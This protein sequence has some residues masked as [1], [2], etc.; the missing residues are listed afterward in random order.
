[1][2]SSVFDWNESLNGNDSWRNISYFSLV[3]CGL[4]ISS[5]ICF[6]V[7]VNWVWFVFEFWCYWLQT[8]QVAQK[9]FRAFNGIFGH[10]EIIGFYSLVAATHVADTNTKKVHKREMKVTR[11]SKRNNCIRQD[12]ARF[13]LQCDFGIKI[14]VVMASNKR[15]NH[16]WPPESFS[17]LPFAT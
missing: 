6:I 13:Q 2:F 14:R 11:K 9:L 16:N 10:K 3:L 17:R 1:M 5:L 8:N 4:F 15:Q 12:N 7:C